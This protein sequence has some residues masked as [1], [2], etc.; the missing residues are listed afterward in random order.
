[1]IDIMSTLTSSVSIIGVYSSMIKPL[2]VIIF[3]AF[4]LYTLFS[5]SACSVGSRDAPPSASMSL[6]DTP[7]AYTEVVNLSIRSTTDTYRP[8]GDLILECSIKNTYKVTIDLR[9]P[10]L[11]DISTRLWIKEH[12]NAVPIQLHMTMIVDYELDESSIVRLHP[13]DTYD[14]IMDINNKLYHMPQEDGQ[15]EVFLTYSNSIGRIY[16]R[17]PWTGCIKS[18]TVTFRIEP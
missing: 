1:L 7:C 3:V 14:F 8:N 11:E 2:N 17:H 10:T 12:G 15:Y 4:V 13:G 16:G 9:K 18:N 5:S 6:L